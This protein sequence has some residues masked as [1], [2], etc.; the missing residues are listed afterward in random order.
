M[1]SRIRE[2]RRKTSQDS[3]R[4]MSTAYPSNINIRDLLN[5]LL[6][7]LHLKTKVSTI[8]R[9]SE[10][11]MP[12]LKVVGCKGIVNLLFALSVVGTTQVRL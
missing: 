1:S 4:A 8:V 11:C 3:R 2:L 6:V 5:L 12:I 10:P 9:I 7:Q